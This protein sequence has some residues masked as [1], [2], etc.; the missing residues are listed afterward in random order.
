MLQNAVTAQSEHAPIS[1]RLAAGPAVLMQAAGAPQI[2][3]SVEVLQYA[4]YKPSLQNGIQN[5]SVQFLPFFLF[6]F[7]QGAVNFCGTAQQLG[8]FHQQAFGQEV[9]FTA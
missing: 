7:S 9:L 6:F 4:T 8:C 1:T 3:Y 5:T 2:A